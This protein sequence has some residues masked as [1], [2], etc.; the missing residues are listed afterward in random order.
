LIPFEV[1]I[2]VVITLL[3]FFIGGLIWFGTGMIKSRLERGD[4]MERRS[5]LTRWI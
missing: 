2:S 3:V 4:K 1:L 5:I